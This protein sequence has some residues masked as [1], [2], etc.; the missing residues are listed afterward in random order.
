MNSI[1][2]TDI[3]YQSRSESGRELIGVQDTA[4]TAIF[5]LRN[6][7]RNSKERLLIAAC[8]IE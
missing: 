2:N 5:E 6:Y 4:E 3:L 7:V 8:T 1:L